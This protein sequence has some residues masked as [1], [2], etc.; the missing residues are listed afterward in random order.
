MNVP[1][2]DAGPEHAPT[3]A[4]EIAGWPPAPAPPEDHAATGDEGGTGSAVDE[5]CC[6]ARDAHDDGYEP[7]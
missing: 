3:Q 1:A 2:D 5:T 6:E 4:G 7:L